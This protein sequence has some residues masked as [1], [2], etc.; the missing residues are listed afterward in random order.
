VVGR[1]PAPLT[2]NDCPARLTCETFT[3]AVP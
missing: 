3:A 2:I 1:S